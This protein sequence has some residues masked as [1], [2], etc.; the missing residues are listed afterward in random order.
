MT[1]GPPTGFGVG[2]PV[3]LLAEHDDFED[4]SLRGRRG[5]LRGGL[6]E[7]GSLLG[8]NVGH[9]GRGPVSRRSQSVAGNDGGVK[10]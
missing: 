4:W 3:L 1:V 5:G 10:G 8:E 2:E 6:D 7:G 9:G